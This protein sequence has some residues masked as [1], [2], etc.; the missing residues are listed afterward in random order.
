MS[1]QAEVLD[2]F[3]WAPPAAP[4][5]PPPPPPAPA[6]ARP[7]AAPRG[8]AVDGRTAAQ[9]LAIAREVAPQLARVVYTR[10][11]R[12]MASLVQRGATLRLN[13]AFAEAPEAVVQAVARLFTARDGRTRAKAR[14]RVREFIRSLPAPPPAERRGPRRRHV[15]P[16]DLP[17]VARLQAEFD[18]V[19][20][21]SFAGA[22]PRVP[23]FLSTAMRRRNGHFCSSP[24]E[25]VISRPLLT[26]A[27]GGEAEATLRHEMIHLWQFA[28]GKKPDHGR[29][30]RAWAKRLDVHP[31]ATRPV[32]WR[33]R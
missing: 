9:T 6:P 16:A 21:E 29:E 7:T 14:G 22:L 13:A 5:K 2:L 3:G 27:V 20:A 28:S 8:P 18:R 24:L 17:L 23:L 12:V 25:I 31:R 33:V 15:A 10:N 1:L 30:F 4:P 19:N 11:R 26:H 32:R